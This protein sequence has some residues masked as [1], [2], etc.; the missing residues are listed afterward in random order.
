[1][2]TDEVDNFPGLLEIPKDEIEFGKRIGRGG[3]SSV[4]KGVWKTKE[5]FPVAIKHLN[6]VQEIELVTLRIIKDD[7]GKNHIGRNF[8]TEVLGVITK[9]PW[10]CIIMEYA[11]KGSLLDYLSQKRKKEQSLDKDVFFT[12]TRQG[13]HAIAYLHEHN[14]IHRDI[15]SPNFL[16]TDRNNLKLCDFG[17]S[18]ITDGTVSTIM[19]GSLAWMAPENHEFFKERSNHIKVSPRSDIYS[20]GVVIWEMWTCKKP[21]DTTM[22]NACYPLD[23]RT[24]TELKKLL[25]QCWE[26]DRMKRP[27]LQDIL[28]HMESLSVTL[29]VE[30]K[31]FIQMPDDRPLP[32]GGGDNAVLE[33]QTVPQA[34]NPNKTFT[35]QH[36]NK[37]SKHL[38][39]EWES[40]AR[41]LGV[42]EAEI[43]QAKHENV[44]SVRNQIFGAFN[45]WRKRKSSSSDFVRISNVIE[46]CQEEQVDLSVYQFLLDV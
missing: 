9:D 5:D 36:L 19:A 17:I 42:T 25:H 13:A 35:E 38:G 37:L 2:A 6:R 45:K 16:I 20:Y 12:W 24:P 29:G 40:L 7:E 30:V 1:M 15:K 44:F 32:G 22:E 31:D 4:F 18:R 23:D 34:K 10:Y 28:N 41:I 8:I 46:A 43:F 11:A 26:N 27:S 3:T 33:E 14:I 21:Q 39:S